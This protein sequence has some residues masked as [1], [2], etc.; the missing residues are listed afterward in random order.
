MSRQE[1]T[2][3]R[4]VIAKETTLGHFQGRDG[5]L[6]FE[7]TNLDAFRNAEAYSAASSTY[8]AAAVNAGAH[9]RSESWWKWYR[10]LFWLIRAVWYLR[11]KA[12]RMSNKMVRLAG[13]IKGLT[14]DQLDIRASIARKCGYHK[15]ATCC[16]AEALHQ[17]G[18]SDNTFVL[19]L[20]HEVAESQRRGNRSKTVLIFQIIKETIK[21]GNTPDMTR[22]RFLR[23]HAKWMEKIGR[24]E[25]ETEVVWAEAEGIA[26]TAGLGDQLVKIRARM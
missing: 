24:P 7:E 23:A 26:K 4:Q 25:E 2:I 1:K 21:R 9:C 11:V 8:Y 10:K 19:L 15:E 18:L 5:A 16:V 22:V 12:W 14:A 20:L 6:E 13:G 17:P 3:L